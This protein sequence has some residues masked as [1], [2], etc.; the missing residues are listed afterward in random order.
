MADRELDYYRGLPSLRIA[1]RH[2]ALARTVDGG[3]HSHQRRLKWS[4]LK[5]FATR[6]SRARGRLARAG[7]FAELHQ[8]VEDAAA[9]VHGI[10]V[11]A[12]YDTVLR[13]SAHL[14]L[15]PE[16]VF[17]HIETT[18]GAEVLGLDVRQATL[19]MSELPAPFGRLKPREVEDRLCIFKSL[20]AGKQRLRKTA[21][22][23]SDSGRCSKRTSAPNEG[24]QHQC[25]TD[26]Q[27]TSATTASTACSGRSPECTRRRLRGWRSASSDT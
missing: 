7:T 3:E 26:I 2:A 21:Y 24:C 12:S 10:D 20:F 17:L 5:E 9:E 1:T 22:S 4:A 11:L 23:C 25:N 14:G 19:E 18:E 16:S 27:L 6:V 13:I 8:V 15:E